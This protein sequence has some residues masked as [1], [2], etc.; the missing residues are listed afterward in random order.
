MN[1]EPNPIMTVASAIRCIKAHSDHFLKQRKQNWRQSYRLQ[2][3]QIRSAEAILENDWSNTEARDALN[4]AQQTLTDIRTS[5]LDATSNTA[6]SSWIQ[7]ADRC[8]HDFFKI[9]KGSK[10]RKLIKKLLRDG[11]TV[12][13]PYDISSYI[14]NYYSNL[15]QSD[16]HTEHSPEAAQT[17]SFVLHSIPRLSL[18]IKTPPSPS[19]FQYWNCRRQSLLF[20][21]EKL[22]D[23]T[24]CQWNSSKTYGI[25]SPPTS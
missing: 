13:H 3:Q 21:E 2:F 17:R 7:L 19:P 6:Q 10:P 12:V 16:S 9:A 20:K 24:A 25:S 22:L 4:L 8:T 1:T 5:K 23:P 14:H 15:Y 11:E 18:L